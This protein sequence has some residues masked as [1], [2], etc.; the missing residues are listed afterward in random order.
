MAVEVTEPTSYV[1]QAIAGVIFAV[2]SL[3]TL[4]KVIWELFKPPKEDLTKQPKQIVLEAAQLADM[5]PFRIIGTELKRTY[6]LK[7]EQLAESKAI[8]AQLKETNEKF[9][10]ILAMMV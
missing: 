9:S 2:V 10:R 3:G 8:S 4:F 7:S 6:D 1:G 5:D